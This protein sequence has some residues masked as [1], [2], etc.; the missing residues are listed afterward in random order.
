MWREYRGNNYQSHV[1]ESLLMTF[2]KWM[3]DS[4]KNNNDSAKYA[5]SRERLLTVFDIVYKKCYN[6]SAWGVLAS[7]ATRFPIFVGMKAMPIYSCR[8]FILWDKTRLS[9][10]LMSPTIS[11]MHPRMFKKR[12]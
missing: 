9:A 6:V 10:E 8:D 4:I 3:M 12:C 5:L 11:P 1:R 7:V 2:E